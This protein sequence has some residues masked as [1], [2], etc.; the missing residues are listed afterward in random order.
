[1]MFSRPV[2]RVIRSRISIR[3]YSPEELGESRIRA[4]E[5]LL[6]DDGESCPFPGG[7][8]FQLIDIQSL[9]SNE[10]K[11]GTY[12]FIKGARY[13]IIGIITR[14]KSVRR[15]GYLFEKRIL[16]LTDMGLGTCW[17]AGSFKRNDVMGFINLEPG[18]SIPAISPVGIPFRPR[19]KERIIRGMVRAR[20]RKPWSQLFFNEFPGTP[21]DESEVARYKIPLEM[22]RLGPSASNR[23]PW[24][25][26]K[27]K[28]G[29]NFHFYTYSPNGIREFQKLDIGIATCHFDLVARELGLDGRWVIED[30]GLEVPGTLIYSISWIA[31]KQ[32]LS[33]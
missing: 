32:H 23:Q 31:G 21:L 4:I 6:V 1:M 13:F 9:D 16:H 33:E 30:P 25:I 10:K 14:E 17:L 24:R 3:T 7:C 20:Q 2:E 27:D 11:L 28:S 18:E 8:R 5:R 12:G 26:I 19:I 22:V 29:Y 15:L